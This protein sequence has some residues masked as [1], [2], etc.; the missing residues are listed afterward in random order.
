MD[1]CQLLGTTVDTHVNT[2]IV[3]TCIL[4]FACCNDAFDI[5]YFLTYYV[6]NPCVVVSNESIMMRLYFHCLHGKD[7]RVHQYH[8]IETNS[9]FC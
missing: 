8:T 9:L 2:I 7:D 3:L 5:I 1:K 6:L 4:S